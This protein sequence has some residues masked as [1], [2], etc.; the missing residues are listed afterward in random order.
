MIVGIGNDLVQVS[1]IKAIVK[2]QGH[3]FA[4]RILTEEEL[5]TLK[6]HRYPEK[7]LAKRFAAKEAAAKALGT[8]IA[9]GVSFHDFQVD[10]DKLGAPL[11]SLSGRAL[12]LAGLKS[13]TSWHLSITDEK[14]YALAMVIAESM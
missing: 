8:G 9:D 1:R 4:Q 7:F 6:N 2:R 3:R 12:E 5:G 10:H 11:L 13:I 14:K